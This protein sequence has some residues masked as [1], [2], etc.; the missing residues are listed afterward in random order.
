MIIP[1]DAKLKRSDLE[2][3]NRIVEEFDCRIQVIQG[4]T[5]EVYAILGDERSETMINRLLGL[6]SVARVDTIQSPYKLMDRKSKLAEQP[7]HLAG[8]HLTQEPLFI[9]GHCTIDTKNPQLFL[10][11]AHAIREAGADLIRGGVWKPRTSPHSYQGSQEALDILVRAKEETKL[12]IVTEVM[13]EAHIEPVIQAGV[14]VIQVGARN[15]LNYSLL[16]AIGK[17]HTSEMSKKNKHDKATILLKRGIHMGSLDEFICAAEYIVA[18]GNRHILLCP[19]GTQ[20][21]IEGYRNYPDESITPLLKTK[22]WAPVIVDPSHS[23]GRAIFVPHAVLSAFA[24]GADGVLI[25]THAHPKR[26]I[27]DDPKQAIQ[28][29]TLKNLIRESREIFR[30]VRK[31]L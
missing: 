20:P 9:A 11:S 10:E 26:G 24:Y 3:I 15:A 4:A 2:E 14:S 19:R 29:E 12:G 21:S 17:A 30:Q 6:A 1:K 22:T 7:L 16:K 8:K 13:E 31:Y 28:P 27:G 23:V 25:E 5:R 18:Q